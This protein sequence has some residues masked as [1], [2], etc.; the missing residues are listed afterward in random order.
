MLQ[1][2]ETLADEPVTVVKEGVE[3]KEALT[4]FCAN[5]SIHEFMT[6]FIEDLEA[7]EDIDK[8]IERWYQ[9]LVIVEGQLRDI[10]NVGKD[11]TTSPE[12]ALDKLT[13]AKLGV[14]R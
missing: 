8:L 13:W 1:I 5:A 9:K 3:I 10:S 14:I 11:L 12:V 4:D 2:S 7:V 6:R